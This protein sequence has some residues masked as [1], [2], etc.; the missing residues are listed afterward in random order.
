MSLSFTE[1]H[2][3]RETVGP[4]TVDVKYY[5]IP[6]IYEPNEENKLHLRPY[7]NKKK[8]E[9]FMLSLQTL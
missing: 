6:I 1:R 8:T 4:T 9:I 5:M 7:P 2:V 3:A